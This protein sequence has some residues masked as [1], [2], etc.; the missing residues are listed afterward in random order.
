MYSSASRQLSAHPLSE[1]THDKKPQTAT[2]EKQCFLPK[3]RPPWIR[4]LLVPVRVLLVGFL[5]AL[6]TF[7][8]CLFLG[9]FGLLISAGV[10]GVHPNM[11]VAY[12]EIAFP[13]AVVAG[14][15]ALLVAIV[16]EVR[17]LRARSIRDA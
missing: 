7:A 14:G 10:R 12:R 15:M 8:V 1:T 3:C 13:A 17:H 2:I 6:L 5:L 16:M 9:I 4:W 11:T